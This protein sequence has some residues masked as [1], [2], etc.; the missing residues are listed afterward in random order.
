MQIERVE[1]FPRANGKVLA[2]IAFRAHGIIIH[3]CL[4]VEKK[5]GERILI[6][7]KNKRGQ[8]IVH[9]MDKPTREQMTAAAIAAWEERTERNEEKSH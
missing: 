1:V 5:S 9:P 3:D 6:M 4:L 7:P 2:K 8:D